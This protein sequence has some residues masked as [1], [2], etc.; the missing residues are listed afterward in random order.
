MTFFLLP[1]L[2]NKLNVEIL[3]LSFND[4]PKNTEYISKSLKF[5][6]NSM[7]K[8]IDDIILEWD[9]YKKYTNPFEYI[10]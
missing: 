3:E 10:H 1:K 7:K 4:D 6:L 2:F 9:I 5:Y 8:K